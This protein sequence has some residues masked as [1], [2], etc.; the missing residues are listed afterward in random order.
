M[1]QAI[2]T[3]YIGPTDHRGA[4]V[5]ATADAGSVTVPWDHALDSEENHTAAALALATKYDWLTSGWTFHAGGMPG[6]NGNV[7]VL[8][9]AE[10]C[11]YTACERDT[12][13]PRESHA[14]PVIGEVYIRPH[15]SRS[16]VEGALSKLERFGPRGMDKLEW[17]ADGSFATLTFAG[18]GEVIRLEREAS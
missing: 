12:N 18:S 7:Y 11:L 15:A 8:A 4:R 5:K 6:G 17:E 10:R 1:R 3:K 9:L 16:E 2:V 14:W 13:E